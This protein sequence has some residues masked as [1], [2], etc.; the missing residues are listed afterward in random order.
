LLYF[1]RPSI[2]VFNRF[3]VFNHVKRFPLR[4]SCYAPC[5]SP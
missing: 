2:W 5:F 4:V 1:V 3:A